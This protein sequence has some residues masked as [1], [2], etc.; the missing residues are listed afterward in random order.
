M[1]E[2]EKSIY[3]AG[4]AMLTERLAHNIRAIEA[5]YETAP[6]EHSKTF[7]DAIQELL[8]RVTKAQEKGTK[9]PLRYIVIS[10]LQLSLYTGRY[11]LRIDAYDDRQFGDLTDTHTYWSPEF[12]FQYID[13]DIA[14]FRKH[15]ARYVRH[16]REYEVMS[17][18]VRYSMHY[19]QIARQFVADL[20]DPA[21]KDNILD[22]GALIVTFG[23]YMDQTDVLF[24]AEVAQ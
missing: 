11:Q 21:L 2:R 7:F 23:G 6:E 3:E 10:Y 19:F 14:Y 8:K 13:A 5:V 20:I 4:E 18:A 12:I 24:E 22:A 9:G 17:F 15:V 1:N 16:V